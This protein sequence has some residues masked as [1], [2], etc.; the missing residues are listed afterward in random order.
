MAT[1]SQALRTLV[2]VE[3]RDSPV[4]QRSFWLIGP[5]LAIFVIFFVLPVGA[6]LLLSINEPFQA[7][8]RPRA[9]FTLEN[10]AHFFTEPL[11]TDA[12]VRTYWVS[13]EV[14]A[15]S[16]LIGYPLAYLMARTES[17]GRSNLLM[18]L[19]LTPLQ[20]DVI[21]RAYGLMVI[22]GDVGLINSSLMK[23]GWITNP[24]PLM[25][26]EFGVVVTLLHVGV[27][28]MVISLMGSIRNIDP[29]LE[30]AA[31]SLGASRLRTFLRITWPLSLPGVLAG[32]LLVFVIAVSSYTVPR[33]VGGG[34]VVTLSTLMYN[35]IQTSAEWQLGAAVAAVLLITSL[36]VVYLYQRLTQRS[37]G[38]LV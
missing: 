19:V 4:Y 37:I 27:P 16:L 10:Y 18:M 7:S 6:L 26:N 13:L 23:L 3:R 12:L 11:F 25:F 21:I 9:N 33:L 20:V 8:L 30:E 15:L 1:V 36:I 24:L 28:I 17:P 38:G 29:A 22:L 32:S 5:P 35:K 34:K 14:T 31:R 2:A